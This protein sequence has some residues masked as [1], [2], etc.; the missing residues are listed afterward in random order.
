VTKLLYK[1][2]S[3]VFKSVKEFSISKQLFKN[4]GEKF[5]NIFISSLIA[6]ATMNPRNS[7]VAA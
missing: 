3:Y 7:Y 6:F 4:I 1:S 2:G 5:G